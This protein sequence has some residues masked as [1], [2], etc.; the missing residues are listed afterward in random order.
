MIQPAGVG[1]SPSCGQR[2]EADRERVLDRLLGDVDVAEDADQDGD[3]AA[4]LLAEDPL[5]LGRREGRHARATAASL[6]NGRTSIGRVVAAAALRPHSSAASRSG[7][8]D[9]S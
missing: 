3:R 6:W 8:L 5:D 1:G 7:G 9:R 4:V 2:S